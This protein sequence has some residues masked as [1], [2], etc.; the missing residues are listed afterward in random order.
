MTTD[1]APGNATDRGSLAERFASAAGYELL[2][3]IF[4]IAGIS[5][6][7]AG[8]TTWVVLALTGISFVLSLSSHLRR[9]KKGTQHIRPTGEFTVSRVIIAVTVGALYMGESP[10]WVVWLATGLLAALIAAEISCA[11]VAWGA[12]PHSVRLPG[13]TIPNKCPFAA[14][15]IF[16]INSAALLVLAASSLAGAS[17]WIGMAVTVVAAVPSAVILL[18]GIYRIRARRIAERRIRHSL[19]EL[20]P[21]FAVHWDAPLGTEY[22]LSM[23]LPYLERLNKKFFVIVRNQGTF[24]AV[25]ALTSAPVLL[26]KTM[27]D[28][29]AMIVPTLKTAFYTNNAVRNSHF[30]RFSELT[31][32]QLNHGDSDK[33][34]SYNPVF[35]MF[36]KNFVAGQAAIDRFA[37]HGVVVPR[38]FFSIVGRPQ[39]EGIQVGPATSSGAGLTVLYAPTWAGHNADSDYSSLPVGYGIVEG[40][41][42]RG[43]TVIFRSH[44]YTRRNKAHAAEADRI[45][46]LLAQDAAATGRPH[47][48]GE[49]AEKTLGMTEC[50]N[51]ADALI[52]DVSSVVPDFLYSEKPFAMA[53]MTASIATFVDE[54]PIARVAYLFDRQL[55]NLE[56]QLDLLLGTDPL[57]QQRHAL[58]SYYLGDFDPAHYADA[59]LTEATK[60]V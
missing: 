28:L 1:R 24:H 7:L 29:D 50:F 11:R 35:R 39:V 9:I 25:S 3:N 18:D 41:V 49:A 52:S 43:C 60:F 27:A 12:I 19:T 45:Q 10:L 8:T 37:N 54:F 57:K 2:T 38:E 53:S 5:A 23:W 26:R 51:A 33:A 31:H 44:P 30:V 14:A 34:P 15:W 58:K 40:L 6:L 42:K 20:A 16:Y 13:I 32:I 17:A 21:T 48:W 56:A 46:S 4:A 36:D 59:F 22:Q 47:R 55:E